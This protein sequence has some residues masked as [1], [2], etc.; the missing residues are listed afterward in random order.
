MEKIC[1]FWPGQAV[2][3][4]AFYF[5]FFTQKERERENREKSGKTGNGDTPE[6]Y[7]ILMN[8]IYNWKILLKIFFIGTPE[9][10]WESF[11]P[12]SYSKNRRLLRLSRGYWGHSRSR[13]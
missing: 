6:V 5:P 2:L 8:I 1:V 11:N 10:F 9:N 3:S 12:T 13:P 7:P 4:Y